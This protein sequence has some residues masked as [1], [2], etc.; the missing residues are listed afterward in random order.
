[1]KLLMEYIYIDSINKESIDFSYTEY[2]KDGT[3]HLEK[4]VSL[5]INQNVD[6]NGDGFPDLLY[7]KPMA[8]REGL[9]KT[10]WLTFISSQE[11]LYTSM[12]SVLPEQYTR[13]VY[14]LGLFGINPDSRFIVSK[15]E[16]DSSTRS[17]AKGLSAGDFV[18]DNKTGKYNKVKGSISYKNA[19]SIEDIDLEIEDD[20]TNVDFYFSEKDFT[21]AYSAV[22]LLKSLPSEITDEY[23]LALSEGEAVEILNTILLK[24]NFVLICMQS[25][26]IEIESELSEILDIT[27]TLSEFE[28]VSFNRMFI[29]YAFKEV[30]PPIDYNCTD[31]TDVLPL[32]SVYIDATEI[33]E[34]NPGINETKR[35]VASNSKPISIS[36]EQGDEDSFK[37][38]SDFANWKGIEFSGKAGYA[39]AS[40]YNDYLKNVEKLENVID[41]YKKI[42]IKSL[43]K[44]I[45]NNTFGI[46]NSNFGN[47]TF[48]DI[49]IKTNLYFNGRF[50][51]SWSSCKAKL[52]AYVKLDASARTCLKYAFSKSLIGGNQN[53]LN[54]EGN[55]NIGPVPFVYGVTGSYDIPFYV[56]SEAN[57]D[58]LYAGFTGLAGAGVNVGADY[59]TRMKKWF[60]VWRKWV[61]R[62]SVYFNPYAKTCDSLAECVYFAGVAN[63]KEGNGLS[64]TAT[65]SPYFVLT[66]YLGVG[67]LSTNINA[68]FP[69]TEQVSV[70]L[71]IKPSGDIYG[72]F[73]NKFGIKFV[74]SFALDLPIVGHKS[75]DFG[76]MDI[77][78]FPIE[79]EYSFPI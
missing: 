60:K 3:K 41:G 23:N 29:S 44:E 16:N 59:G 74:G 32:V 43:S 14:P 45:K 78:G 31:I 69:V 36:N 35:A 72:S 39:L 20:I 51:I 73:A 75:R 63:A 34:E 46:E 4:S 54:I 11:N 9:E 71:E 79:K 2:S 64:I 57:S 30:C 53:F 6:L 12:F 24:T 68:N 17:V 56:D 19:R 55:F 18:L 28:I 49:N 21:T 48:A 1:M 7:T 47:S 33:E 42:K 70:R 40:S 65:V 13:G 61:Y 37:I 58:Y 27:D 25:L 8:K 15:Y 22:E 5:G 52:A 38:I 76:K 10:L 77:K 26:N 50:T 66:P 62:P 67:K